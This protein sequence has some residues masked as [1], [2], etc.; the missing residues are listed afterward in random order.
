MICN[1]YWDW[2][3]G[4]D[5]GPKPFSR[6]SFW[7]F[8]DNKK[9]LRG[10]IIK[11]IRLRILP[12][13]SVY[14]FWWSQVASFILRKR[15]LQRRSTGKWDFRIFSCIQ[16]M[17]DISL[18]LL[19]HIA[20]LNCH[21]DHKSGLQ[22]GLEPGGFHLILPK[23]GISPCFLQHYPLPQAGLLICLE[24][25]ICHTNLLSPPPHQSPIPKLQISLHYS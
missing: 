23:S 3:S 10:S 19:A 24:P 5:W 16:M 9:S 6:A 25:N 7:Y 8:S 22:A 2:Q 17:W 14:C 21:P 1:L 15:D 4:N 13:S 18:W 12:F 11:K 20:D